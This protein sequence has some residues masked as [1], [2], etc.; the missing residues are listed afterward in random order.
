MPAPNPN[1]LSSIYFN[2]F[3]KNFFYFFI[4][5]FLILKNKIFLFSILTY[6]ILSC[7]MFDHYIL[8]FDFFSNFC[9]NIYVRREGEMINGPTFPTPHLFYFALLT[10]GNPHRA[11][12]V[13]SFFIPYKIV[14]KKLYTGYCIQPQYKKNRGIAAPRN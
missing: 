3:S 2:I 7:Q 1:N 8:R 10:E 5:T 11:L 4:F 13:G 12:A 6:K 9:Y 14:Y